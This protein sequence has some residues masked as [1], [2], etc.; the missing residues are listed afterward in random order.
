M[1]FFAIMLARDRANRR[2][3][4]VLLDDLV[5][6]FVSFQGKHRVRMDWLACSF[7]CESNGCTFFNRSQRTSRDFGRG[8]RFRTLAYFASADDILTVRSRWAV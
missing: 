5:D 4:P 6:G 1:K 3:E 7:N 2:D 8:V